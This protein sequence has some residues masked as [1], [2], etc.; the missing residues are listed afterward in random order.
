M[1]SHVTLYYMALGGNLNSL[2]NLFILFAKT[3]TEQG[4][5]SDPF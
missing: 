1:R 2:L 4:F 5:P 3:L